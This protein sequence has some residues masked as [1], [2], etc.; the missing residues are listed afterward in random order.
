MIISFE[1]SSFKDKVAE[2]PDPIVRPP[3]DLLVLIAL[4][5]YHGFISVTCCVR[6][7]NWPVCFSA[8]HPPDPVTK[9]NT[10]L[11]WIK[12]EK[13]AVK[14]KD[15]RSIVYIEKLEL[16]FV[17]PTDKCVCFIQMV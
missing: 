16:A 6:P 7:E 4:K 1:S 10:V 13:T 11:N 9:K 8:S 3:S 15:K 5:L 14:V 17:M 12:V 2:G